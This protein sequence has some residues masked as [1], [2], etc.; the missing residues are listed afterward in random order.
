MNS[1]G[2]H[3]VVDGWV[4]CGGVISDLLGNW[5]LSFSKFIGV[6]FV[7]EAEL[8]GVLV[9]L[10]CAWKLHVTKLVVE[11]DSMDA[12][13]LIQSSSGDHGVLSVV[14][15]NLELCARPWESRF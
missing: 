3:R 10:W 4:L 5:C 15:H 12:L 7:V 14:L 1:Y 2:A 13:R 8:W 9:G 11:I 6:C